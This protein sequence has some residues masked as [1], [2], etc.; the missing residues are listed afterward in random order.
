MKKL[1]KEGA[2]K[3]WAKARGIV[4]RKGG[5]LYD[6]DG[7]TVTQGWGSLACMLEARGSIR[8]SWSDGYTVVGPAPNPAPGSPADLDY[9]TVK[10]SAMRSFADLLD[11]HPSYRPTIRP[12]TPEHV[13]LADAYDAAMI[14]RGDPRRVYRGAHRHFPEHAGAR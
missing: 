8:G 13:R 4:G 12:E 3:R 6:A 1:T 14:E 11:T 9:L 10:L 2:A 5:W 7:R